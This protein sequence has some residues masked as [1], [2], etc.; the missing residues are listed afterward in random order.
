MPTA[1]PFPGDVPRGGAAVTLRDNVVSLIKR[2]AVDLGCQLHRWTGR[3]GQGGVGVLMYH[4]V[5]EHPSGVDL[6]T[7][8]VT[9]AM[10]RRQIAGLLEHGCQPWPLR[11]LIEEPSEVPRSGRIFAVTFDDGYESVF[12]NAVP[13][14][15]ELN[16][17]ATIFLP[18]AY[19]D[20]NRR[21]P[22]DNWSMAGS[23]LVPADT[24]RPMT[25]N[26]CRE[27]AAD[28]LI[29]FGGHTHTHRDLSRDPAEFLRDLRRN[30]AWLRSMLGVERPTFS[31]PFGRTTSELMEAARRSGVICALTTAG[32]LVDL[33]QSPFGWGRFNVDAWDTAETLMIK[34][35]NWY[36]WAS[37][38]RRRI[39][40]PAER[41]NFFR[42]DDFPAEAALNPH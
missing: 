28:G 36:S 11:R 31:F 1:N 7:F 3:R 5:A 32:T 41:P 2:A 13:I 38:M 35:S 9:P 15:R 40:P 29:E 6:P 18:T 24:W 30:V 8:N 4:R 19:I 20:G 16:V 39:A 37:R 23:D 21:F 25:T 14:L 34:M 12:R 33:N 42:H 10:F 27:A 17:P 26:Q 22:F